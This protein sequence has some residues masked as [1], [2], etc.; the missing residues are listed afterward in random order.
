MY[1][2]FYYTF[3]I[4]LSST[5]LVIAQTFKCLFSFSPL[6]RLIFVIASYRGWAIDGF[7]NLLTDTVIEWLYSRRLQD[8]KHNKAQAYEILIRLSYYT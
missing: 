3:S 7:G 8:S 2:V 4:L 6:Y 1:S 5:K